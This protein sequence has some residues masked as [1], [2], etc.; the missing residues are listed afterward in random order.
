[1]PL[2]K[3]HPHQRLIW[4][5]LTRAL[6]NNRGRGGGGGGLRRSTSGLVRAESWGARVERPASFWSDTKNLNSDIESDGGG[7][8]GGGMSEAARVHFAQ[9]P[10]THSG[11]PVE[12][13]AFSPANSS[14]VRF[15]QLADSLEPR[16]LEA[17]GRMG[18]DE[19]TPVQRGAVPVGL[20]GLDATVQA[21][22]GSGKTL[23][24]LVPLVSR[25]A[26]NY[27]AQAMELVREADELTQYPSGL[28]I[29][30]TR[31]LAQQILADLL[32]LTCFTRISC[33][34]LVGGLSPE[35]MRQRILTEGLHIAVA[36][37]GRLLDFMQRGILSLTACRQLVLDEA[38]RCLDM[39]F[40]RDI[41]RI[42]SSREFGMPPSADRQTSLYSA[43]FPS[44]VNRIVRNLMRPD[45]CVSVRAGR[46]ESGPVPAGISQELRLIS[47]GEA[48]R[49]EALQR[50][51]AELGE[52][53]RCLL[54][55]RTKAGADRLHRRLLASGF[56]AATIHGD[57][58][59]H[60]RQLSLQSFKSGRSSV[61][62]ATDVAA[63]GLDLPGVGLVVNFDAPMYMDQ[64]IHR[65]GRTGRLGRPG[66]AVTFLDSGDLRIGDI[67]KGLL[68]VLQA[69]KQQVPDFLVNYRET[70]E[71]AEDD[72]WVTR[73]PN[74]G[75][76]GVPNFKQAVWRSR[77]PRQEQPQHR[78][79]GKRYN[80]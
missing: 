41:R 43:T 56:S 61:L 79:A 72:G 65:V 33:G 39:G 22:T 76:A 67:R 46:A 25:L 66:R 29:C 75:P 68:Q 4:S 60:S 8:G 38:D 7:G 17:L 20:A 53:E 14:A 6:H 40:E 9:V 1:H 36:T 70:S 45:D 64:Y 59:Q 21:E 50:L 18:V 49:L 71:E 48:Q 35:P 5:L 2:S 34:L 15:S 55:V 12:S 32:R 78:R 42:V 31:E 30:P 10:L 58:K 11:R 62:I 80:F 44:D 51:L 23:A 77:G 73:K 54:F 63:R 3:L 16:V 52:G 13:G 69:C 24:Y 26:A 37:P 27:P 28:I 74:R 57:M 19:M 47:R